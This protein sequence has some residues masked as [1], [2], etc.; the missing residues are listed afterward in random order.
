MS[1]LTNAENPRAC[2]ERRFR[3]RVRGRRARSVNTVRLG[4]LRS[5]RPDARTRQP[6]SAA[7]TARVLR[8]TH[9]AV[10]SSTGR[11]ARDRGEHELEARHVRPPGETRRTGRIGKANP[12]S[13]RSAREREASIGESV[14]RAGE[15]HPG[16]WH[17]MPQTGGVRTRSAALRRS[18]YHGLFAGLRLAWPRCGPECST[19]RGTASRFTVMSARWRGQELRRGDVVRRAT[20]DCREGP[21]VQGA[22]EAVGARL[23]GRP[24]FDPVEFA[25]RQAESLLRAAAAR[26]GAAPWTVTSRERRHPSPL[27]TLG[28]TER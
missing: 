28:E 24:G 27:R 12:S 2:R 16:A 4:I 21:R 14:N 7:K 15:L 18:A 26:I 25:V 22:A 20:L 1:A 6:Q 23:P 8:R 19:V 3:A 5:S 11:R 10:S 17:I 13:N 9:A